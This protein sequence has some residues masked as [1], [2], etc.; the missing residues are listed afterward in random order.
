MQQAALAPA[1]KSTN[2]WHSERRTLLN[3]PRGRLLVVLV[4]QVLVLRDMIG[5]VVPVGL[6]LLPA[7]D[8]GQGGEVGEG[9]GRAGLMPL[10]SCAVVVV[11]VIH[12]TRALG[13]SNP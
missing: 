9:M 13:L 5:W 11:R 3:I 4:V 12:R 10:A 1:L 6:L 7:D 2:P 8:V